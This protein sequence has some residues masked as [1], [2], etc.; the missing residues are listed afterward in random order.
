[1]LVFIIGYMASGKTTL[2]QLLAQRLNYRFVDLDEMIEIA[3]GYS[4][5]DFFEKFGEEQFRQKEREVLLTHLNDTDTIIATGG[6]TPC[7]ADNM[8]L[9]NRSGITLF[10]DTPLET[11][12]QRL[13]GK[14]SHRPLLNRIP[15]Q[16]IPDFIRNHLQSR[17]PYYEKAKLKVTGDDYLLDEIS[18]RIFRIN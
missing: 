4:I 14:I 16:Q 11:I 9:M 17:L 3:S 1:M 12:L 18:D 8:E 5:S 6:G 15:K 2:G 10:L 7:H 13:S